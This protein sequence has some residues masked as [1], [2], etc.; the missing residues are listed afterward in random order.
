MFP[1]LSVNVASHKYQLQK[2]RGIE[3]TPYRILVRQVIFQRKV[4]DVHGLCMR[5]ADGVPCDSSRTGFWKVGNHAPDGMEY[6]GLLGTYRDGT[7]GQS[8]CR[9]HS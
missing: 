3:D 8:K 1:T 6:L 7:G 5:V 9:L 4:L 2:F